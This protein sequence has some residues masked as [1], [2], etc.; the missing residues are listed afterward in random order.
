MRRWETGRA[1][2]RTQQLRRLERALGLG[3]SL[4]GDAA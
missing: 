4:L 2:P 3:V 1:R